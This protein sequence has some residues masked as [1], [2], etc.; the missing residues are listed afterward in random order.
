MRR[1]LPFAVITG[2]LCTAMPALADNEPPTIVHTPVGDAGAGERITLVVKLADESEVFPPSIY[3]RP[4]GTTSWKVLN[5]RAR[6]GRYEGVL[7]VD[8]GIEYWIEAYDEFGNGPALSGSA[9]QPHL[10][11][12]SLGA[13]S[14]GKAVAKDTSPPSI[15]HEPVKEAASGELTVTATI[16]DPS[17]VFAPTMY[18][19][20][21]GALAYTSEIMVGDG[22]QFSA[23]FRVKPPVDYWIEAYDNLGNGP[24]Y[25][26]TAE[27][28]HRVE[29]KA[30][31]RP[32]V[33]VA[34]EVIAPELPLPQVPE[35]KI[36]TAWWVGGAAGVVTAAVIGGVV[37]AFTSGPDYGEWL[38]TQPRRR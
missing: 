19:R 17:G 28:P 32:I 12:V 20:G 11:S 21:P 22:D 27:K 8:T 25:D 13:K 34:P 5:L 15:R 30:E 2:L 24:A 6:Q 26:G 31:P 18:H 33:E 29:L 4:V 23:T 3:Y 38:V 10:V 9:K 16:V 35:K 14:V 7:K 37:Y 36:P 1:T